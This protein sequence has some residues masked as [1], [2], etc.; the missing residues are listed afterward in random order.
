MCNCNTCRF[1]Y[2]ES[3]EVFPPTDGTLISFNSCCFEAKLGVFAVDVL[4]LR[5]FA[6]GHPAQKF[7]ILSFPYGGFLLPGQPDWYFTVIADFIG[8]CSRWKRLSIPG[9]RPILTEKLLVLS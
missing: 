7:T 8:R 1:R 2:S 9:W 4:S 6:T 5:F 3:S